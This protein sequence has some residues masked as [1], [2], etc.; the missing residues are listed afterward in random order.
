MDNIRH[1]AQLVARGLNARVAWVADVQGALSS[2][3][4]GLRNKVIMQSPVDALIT[5]LRD[6][7]RNVDYRLRLFDV[8][9]KA[10]N[11]AAA[12]HS[13][14]T[15]QLRRHEHRVAVPLALFHKGAPRTCNKLD[16]GRT[17]NLRNVSNSHTHLFVEKVFKGLFL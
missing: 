3:L 17:F 9:G 6:Y 12:I 2:L 16:N 11:D 5:I 14:D 15:L 4:A 1:I 10:A 8:E 7:V 13:K